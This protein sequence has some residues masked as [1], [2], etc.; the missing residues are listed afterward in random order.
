MSDTQRSITP[1]WGPGHPRWSFGDVTSKSQGR[2]RSQGG[3]RHVRF[4]NGLQADRALLLVKVDELREREARDE[5]RAPR[6]RKDHRRPVTRDGGKAWDR[7]VRHS[8][9]LAWEVRA[10]QHHREHRL[11]ALTG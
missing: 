8:D 5:E 2:D 6:R 3:K 11:P 1:G 10:G 9:A 4:R 7:M